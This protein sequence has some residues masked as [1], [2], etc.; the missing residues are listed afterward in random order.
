MPAQSL[1]CVR[2]T[3]ALPRSPR[4]SALR[5]LDLSQVTLHPRGALGAWQELN[6]SATIPRCIAQLETSGVIDNFRRLVGESGAEHRGFVFADSDLYKVIEAVAW[7]I[8]RSGTTVH[9]D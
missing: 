6:A 3:P 4:G 9:D 7:E 8:G 2:P 1:H 5:P